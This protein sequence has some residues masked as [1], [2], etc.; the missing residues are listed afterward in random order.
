MKV[1]HFKS[2]FMSHH[3]TCLDQYGQ[4]QILKLL[5]VESFIGVGVTRKMDESVT[6]SS[7]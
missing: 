3:I 6:F 5:L 2:F 7:K 1:L 4:H